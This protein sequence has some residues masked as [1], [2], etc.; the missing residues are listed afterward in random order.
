MKH[1]TTDFFKK[2][3]FYVENQR[4]DTIYLVLKNITDILIEINEKGVKTNK[5]NNKEGDFYIKKEVDFYIKGKI[6]KSLE[7]NTKNKY[8]GNKVLKLTEK[9][10]DC[11]IYRDEMISMI[12]NCLNIY[13]SKFLKKNFYRFKKLIVENLE[14]FFYKNDNFRSQNNVLKFL[15]QFEKSEE[16]FKFLNSISVDEEYKENE[17]NIMYALILEGVHKNINDGNEYEQFALKSSLLN[18]MRNYSGNSIR[19]LKSSMCVLNKVNDKYF[20]PF[21]LRNLTKF[22]CCE[23]DL[24]QQIQLYRKQ[25]EED[26]F[27]ERIA[28]NC[29]FF[30]PSF[31]ISMLFL[32]N[33]K[34]Y[35][36]GLLRFHFHPKVRSIAEKM[37]KGGVLEKFDPYDFI[38]L[39]LE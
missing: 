2:L 25:N 18:F 31:I 33:K 28:K 20:K 34:L 9:L 36:L 21:L 37:M 6:I 22:R 15:S 13:E 12:I 24:I 17:R 14:E 4:N 38:L 19:V 39:D 7:I 23:Y 30:S 11:G 8:I 16:I 29:L 35:L 26:D 32:S 1:P 27:L 3:L 10:T 5:N